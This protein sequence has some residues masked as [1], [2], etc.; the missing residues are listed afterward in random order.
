[1]RSS[2][3]KASSAT[4]CI[5]LL[6]LMLTPFI[7]AC[8]ESLHEHKSSSHATHDEASAAAPD[9]GPH[10]GRLLRDGAFTLELA[11][12]DL[13]VPP[14]F[15]AYP[16][17]NGQNL[18]PDDVELIIKLSRLG[19]KVDT[20]HFTPFD[21][22]L[23]SNTII[24]EPHSFS[25]TIHATH[26]GQTHSWEY[27]NIE[28]RTKIE[29]AIAEA[30]AI[31]TAIAGPQVIQETIT[32]YGQIKANQ[33]RLRSINAR[34]DGVI[35]SVLPSIGD[36]VHKGQK[37]AQVE[38]NESLQRYAITSPING[39]VI[40]R[41][42]NAGEQTQGRELF[43]I[44]DI[45]SVW[46]DLS[47]F[48]ADLP[49]VKV[50]AAVAITSTNAGEAVLGKVASIDIRAQANQSVTA[51][52]VLDNQ[53]GKL[54]PG[55]FVTAKIQVDEHPVG[56]AVRRSGLQSFRDFTVVYA[57]FGDEYEVRMLELGRQAGAWAEVLG[58]LEAGT[59]YV[60]NNSYVIKADIEKSGAAHDH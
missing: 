18:N 46:V 43:T 50:G 53:A 60:S 52:M 23:R 55:S 41:N 21:D 16:S 54:L 11:I 58:G 4:T 9:T 37:L 29:A 40:E 15:R 34:F 48:P 59:R 44:L 1:M 17:Y 28:G 33:E 25:V 38:S 47:V 7:N 39:V 27:E 24:Y 6:V 42:A 12:F 14:E 56:L 26:A 5:I 51:R 2:I 13:G 57:Q 31:E 3:N 32:V 22:A 20:I 10:G 49:R 35:K 8:N 19:G 30:L 36:T 45:S